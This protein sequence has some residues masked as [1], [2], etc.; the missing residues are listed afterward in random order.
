[1]DCIGGRTRGSSNDEV[2]VFADVTCPGRPAG[3]L[4]AGAAT[5]VGLCGN[6]GGAE[7]TATEVPG[8]GMMPGGVFVAGLATAGG[9]VA[10][11]VEAV[12]PLPAVAVCVMTVTHAVRVRTKIFPCD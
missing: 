5:C 11:C 10:S 9:R 8:F 6:A 3:T 7:L 2:V 1:M 4:A 12:R